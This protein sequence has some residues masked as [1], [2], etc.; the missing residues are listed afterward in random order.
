L[1]LR[2]PFLPTSSH[3]AGQIYFN[4]ID[5]LRS[6]VAALVEFTGVFR[7]LSFYRTVKQSYLLL[8]L[9]LARRGRAYSEYGN[10]DVDVSVYLSH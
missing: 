7:A 10:N 8:L 6:V 1:N 5:F 3:C 2:H 4:P 9:L